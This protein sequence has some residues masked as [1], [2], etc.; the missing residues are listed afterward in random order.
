MGYKYSPS[1]SRATRYIQNQ[2]MNYGRIAAMYANVSTETVTVTFTIQKAGNAALSRTVNIPSNNSYSKPTYEFLGLPG[3]NYTY[4]IADSL[5]NT[6]SGTITIQL[7]PGAEYNIRLPG[8]N[9]FKWNDWFYNRKRYKAVRYSR[10]SVGKVLPLPREVAQAPINFQIIPVDLVSIC[11]MIPEYDSFFTQP[12]RGPI[13]YFYEHDFWYATDPY[14]NGFRRP[15]FSFMVYDQGQGSFTPNSEVLLVFFPFSQNDLTN[16]Y[17][18]L[19]ALFPYPRRQ[20]FYGYDIQG[21][22]ARNIAYVF[23]ET[24]LDSSGIAPRDIKDFELTTADTSSLGKPIWKSPYAG[25]LR[26]DDVSDPAWWNTDVYGPIVCDWDGPFGRGLPR[27]NRLSSGADYFKYD[28]SFI[29]TKRL[30]ADDYRDVGIT[31]PAP[32]RSLFPTAL[33][34]KTDSNGRINGIK[35]NGLQ[36]TNSDGLPNDFEGAMMLDYAARAEWTEDPWFTVCQTLSAGLESDYAQTYVDGARTQ[37]STLYDPIFNQDAYLPLGGTSPL[38]ADN[39]VKNSVSTGPY[40]SGNGR[41]VVTSHG[42]LLANAYLFNGSPGSNYGYNLQSILDNGEFPSNAVQCAFLS[43]KTI[44]GFKTRLEKEIPEEEILDNSLDDT[45]VGVEFEDFSSG[46]YPVYLDK[47][48]ERFEVAD[49]DDSPNALNK[50]ASWIQQRWFG[51]TSAVPRQVFKSR[52]PRS[53]NGDTRFNSSADFYINPDRQRV[54]QSWATQTGITNIKA[55]N[56]SKLVFIKDAGSTDVLDF[57]L[58]TNYRVSVNGWKN[59]SEWVLSELVRDQKIEISGCRNFKYAIPGSAQIFS[60]FGT[61]TVGAG[62]DLS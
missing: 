27:R 20:S 55:F 30:D 38:S 10:V 6:A 5:G 51:G 11:R 12:T 3:G 22:K 23:P 25:R 58:P 26:R 18:N 50:G 16:G 13:C 4:T 36:P 52:A 35:H 60:E 47:D 19:G 53:E 28:D 24:I 45:L 17:Q 62:V 46:R 15:F 43:N 14:S 44:K 2:D 37:K 7:L 59:A 42:T 61:T 31:E 33:V 40:G 57:P 8:L 1:F 39:L 48:P 54:K 34:L 49:H 9:I 41:N 56:L 21:N 29:P 32:M